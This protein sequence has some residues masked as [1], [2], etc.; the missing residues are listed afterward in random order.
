MDFIHDPYVPGETIAALAT[1]PG[2]GGIAVIRVTGDHAIAVVD[3]IF[4]S[5]V[6]RF[7]THTAHYGHIVGPEGGIVDSVLVLVMKGRRSFAGED[8]VEI[9]CHGGSL[10]SRRVLETVY[11]AGAR[12]AK[13]GEFS[14]R[15]FINGKL[16]LAQAEA[17]QELISADNER[18]MEAAGQQLEGR[19]SREVRRYQE[20]LTDIAG[21]LEA[22]VDFPEE[23]LEFAT[24]DELVG[25]LAAVKQSLQHLVDT[26][27]DG[28]ILHEGIALALV[29]SPNAGK[30]SLMNAL[31]DKE[32]AIV[33]HIAGTTRDLLED[34]MRLNGLHLKLIDTA[35]IREAE[36]LVEQ[37]GIRRSR[38]AMK[39]ADLVLL[40]VDGAMG[41]TSEVAALFAE[42]PPQKTIV[43]WNK[44]DLV[45]G[46]EAPQL[47]SVPVL[48]LSAKERWGLD[49]LKRA[50]DA[51]IWA[52]GA[53]DKGELLITSHR[54]Y[55]ALKEAIAAA[56][57]VI[58]GLACDVSPEFVTMDMRQCLSGVGKILGCNISE[59]I[60]SSIFSRFCIGK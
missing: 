20:T 50:I 31:L 36:E 4:S 6:T 5:D 55:E 38:Q 28:R 58:D 26:Y 32:R 3:R 43:V 21:I 51:I 22:W 30:S 35:G 39:S 40:V 46:L 24:M 59:D 15:A 54:H 33:T 34:T 8:T 10:I 45:E 1:P 9:H 11:A 48:P 29:G 52:H 2:E 16:D 60:L 53:P 44:C 7:A 12:P 56:E 18:A 37:E 19:L 47:G 42:L 17:I 14:F 25:Q 27:H 13:P 57:R 23:G 41:W 49:E